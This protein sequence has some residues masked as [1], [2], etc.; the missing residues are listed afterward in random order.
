M[1]RRR[2]SLAIPL[3]AA[4]FGCQGAGPPA[5]AERP[6]GPPWFEDVTAARGLRFVH[7]P[8]PVGAYFMPQIM[9]SGCALFDYDG[10]GRLDAYLIQNAGP[11]SGATN[12]L[13]HQEADGTFRDVTAG[14]GLGVAGFGMGVAVGDVNND[15]RPDVLVTEYG[16]CRLFL[17]NG[18]GTFTDVTKDAGLDDLGWGTS[19]AFFDYDRDGWLDLIVVNYVDYD[20]SVRCGSSGGKPDYCHPNTFPGSVARLYHNLGPARGAAPV[21]FEDVTVKAGLARLPSN[22]LGVLC[23]DFD[24]DGWPDVFVA[25][26]S[27]ANHLWMNQKNGTFK[28]EAVKRG[29][30]LNGL[31]QTAANMGV[32]WGDVRGKRL[33]DLFVTHLGDEDHT[34]WRQEPQGAYQDR[35]VDAGLTGGRWRGTGFG[36]A[37]ADFDNDGALDLAVVN[38]RV[39]RRREGRGDVPESQFWAQYAE[40]AQLFVN[41]GGGRFRDASVD[42]PALCREPLVG[43][44]LAVGDL[45]DDGGLDLLVTQAGGPARLLHNVAPNRGAWL[46]VRAVDPA[47]NRDAYG[48]EITVWAG[49]R[50]WVGWVNPGSS[51]LSSC[52]PRAHFGLGSVQRYDRLR[53]AWPDGP[54]KT[55]LEEFRGGDVNKVREVHRGEGTPVPA[56]G[57]GT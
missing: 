36:A 3:L 28:E 42:N 51:Y 16:R 46:T 49:D 24:G 4:V 7:D 56:E 40:R 54:V 57:R 53:V 22:G 15:G 14:S 35:T 38:G 26:D 20:R 2:L 44:G 47:R 34:L 55:A 39:T 50:S 9:G 5:D 19:A 12:R 27:K 43:R 25:N 30:A 33:P 45:D 11:D 52:D 6:E 32:A 10:D 1:R 17:N 31:G 41:A 29:V 23:A 37:L 48:A 13:F 8:G 21:R 18:N